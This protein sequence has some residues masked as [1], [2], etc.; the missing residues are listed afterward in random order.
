MVAGAQTSEKTARAPPPGGSIETLAVLGRS[1]RGVH[2]SREV[3]PDHELLRKVA[4]GDRTAFGIVFDRH[5]AAALRYARNL[6]R[7]PS[8][9]E[10]LVH[11]AFVRLLEASRAGGI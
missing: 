8:A 1:L 2:L 9:S 3:E 10:D 4:R 11:A 7:D 5:A 6:I